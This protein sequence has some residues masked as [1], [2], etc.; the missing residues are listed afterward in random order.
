MM[1]ETYT[2]NHAK[3]T[4]CYV[5]TRFSKTW[6]PSSNPKKNS[7]VQEY[8]LPNFSIHRHGRLKL[9]SDELSA[10]DQVL[11]MENERFTIPELLFRLDDIATVA[12]SI[13]L[14]D[15]IRGMFWANIGLTGGNA[16]FPGFYERLSSELLLL[17]PVEYD[18]Q[19]YRSQDAVTEAYR[20][21]LAFAN[22][23]AFSTHVVTR[24]EKFTGWQL[25]PAPRDPEISKIVQESMIED[26]G[27][28][29]RKPSRPRIR[30]TTTSGR[31]R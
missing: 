14:P 20:S 18:L 7:I 22:D 9:P 12:T 31:R 27:Q 28:L 11:H 21:A 1:D 8:I 25:S 2:M 17:A 5:S 16:N 29:S 4:C 13:S 10:T 26:K 19:I 23:P 24:A 15:D 6:R 30:T 3:E